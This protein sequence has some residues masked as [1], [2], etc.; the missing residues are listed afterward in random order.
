MSNFR[1]FDKKLLKGAL[2]GTGRTYL[3]LTHKDPQICWS[4]DEY[5]SIS[6]AL[7]ALLYLKYPL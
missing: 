2:N 7:K 1:Y 4:C 6:L 5:H 3:L